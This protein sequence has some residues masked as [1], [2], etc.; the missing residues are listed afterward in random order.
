MLGESGFIVF[1]WYNGNW[2]VLSDSNLIGCIFG[3]IL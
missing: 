2:S 3:L 1:D